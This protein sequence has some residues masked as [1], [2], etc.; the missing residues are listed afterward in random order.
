M[1]TPGCWKA[2]G[3][4]KGSA[5]LGAS[6]PPFA[7]VPLHRRAP[8]WQRGCHKTCPQPSSGHAPAPR[9]RRAPG[10]AQLGRL[11]HPFAALV[12]PPGAGGCRCPGSAPAGWQFF[13]PK[14]AE[15]EGIPPHCRNPTE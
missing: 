12:G 9:C 7:N 1:G 13:P 8:G 6:V 11:S 4:L 2:P 5:L 15:Q 10:P 3:Q 14:P